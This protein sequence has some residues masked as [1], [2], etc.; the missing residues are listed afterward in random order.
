MN[1]IGMS[2]MRDIEMPMSVMYLRNIFAENTES[3]AMNYGTIERVGETV[4]SR[5]SNIWNVP[6]QSMITRGPPL[7]NRMQMDFFNETIEDNAD[8]NDNEPPHS[9]SNI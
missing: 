8:D 2:N 6:A 9:F 5:L 3:A 1:N 7:I 4:E